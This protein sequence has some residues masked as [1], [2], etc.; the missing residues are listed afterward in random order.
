M[1]LEGIVLR[2]VGERQTP[3]DLSYAR[4]LDTKPKLTDRYR[5]T[6]DEGTNVGA[7]YLL[8]GR[9]SGVCMVRTR[10]LTQQS[11]RAAGSGKGKCQVGAQDTEC[12]E[13]FQTTAQSTARAFLPFFP[14]KSTF[15]VLTVFPGEATGPSGK[16]RILVISF[17]TQ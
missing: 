14:V 10:S 15:P 9:R 2:S 16:T 8:S 3:R 11:L 7:D 17:A 4:N 5:G 13:F 1:A 12:R 6:L